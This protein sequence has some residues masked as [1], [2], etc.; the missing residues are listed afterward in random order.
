M[1]LH[2]FSHNRKPKDQLNFV[3]CL[4]TL[5]VKSIWFLQLGVIGLSADKIN[6]SPRYN[7]KSSTETVQHCILG[8]IEIKLDLLM[9][10]DINKISNFCRTK[11]TFL[12]AAK[13]IKLEKIIFGTPI[14]KKHNVKLHFAKFGRN[15]SGSFKTEQGFSKVHL[16]SNF[17]D[18][19]F[20]QS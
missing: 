18:K 7:I 14:L 6:R 9:Q 8:E 11:E 15:I 3:Q 5:E 20:L 19:K 12:V 10:S 16:K 17:S 1:F 13:S 2:S 4:L